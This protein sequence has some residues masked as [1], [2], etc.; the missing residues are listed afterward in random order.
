MRSALAIILTAPLLFGAGCMLYFGG[1][2]DPCAWPATEE[3]AGEPWELINPDTGQCE[4]FGGDYWCD[5]ACCSGA[6]LWWPTWGACYSHCTDLD[7]STCLGTSGC[8]AAYLDPCRPGDERCTPGDTAAFYGCWATDTTG[9]IQ[10]GGCDGLDALECS[11]HDDC[12]AIH[13]DVCD[14]D[15]PGVH[16]CLGPF[17][18]CRD[19]PTSG[20][21][22]CYGD[23]DCGDDERCNAAEVCLPSPG[24]DGLDTDCPG[25][26]YGWCVP[27][28][29]HDPGTCYGEV[30]CRALPPDC[31]PGTM[32]GI[33]DLCWTGYCIPESDCEEPPACAALSDE[34]ACIARA[35][36]A[37]LYHGLDCT[38]T[39]DGC[40]CAEWQFIGC[41][42]R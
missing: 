21:A 17:S 33:K 11:R 28:H 39:D 41:E 22:G 14:G 19:E 18:T 10:G 24:C 23:Q 38:C 30:G 1:D 15:D 13:L 8:R 32:P 35:D 37:P 2:D 29:P 31:P 16:A 34:P 7:E 6:D 42:D 4:Y 3:G 9:P 25:V 26:C 27:D 20:P 36:C 12:V 40:T 5:D